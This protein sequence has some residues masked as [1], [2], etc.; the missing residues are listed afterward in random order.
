[1]RDA[2][3]Q[4]LVDLSRYLGDPDRGYAILGEGN[5]SARIDEDTF[6]V[7]ASGSVL[8]N[9]DGG[10]FVAVS[11]AKVLA[12]LDDPGADDAAVSRVLTEAR[13]D[14]GETRRPSVETLFHALLL[15]YPE[16][17]FVGHT[18]PIHT[19]ML[20]CSKKAEEAST[21]RICPDHVVVMAA[22]SV[23]VPYVDP[24]LVLARE[25]RARV[26]AFIETEGTLP[27]AIMMQGHGFIAVGDS[28]R[29]VMNITDMAEKA[30][31][32]IVGTYSLGG[33]VFMS[34]KDIA[35]IYTRPDEKYREKRLASEG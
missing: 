3:L 13:V 4:Q 2:I 26:E 23:F 19:N 21:G 10:G 9:I 25:I 28:P 30:A 14:P 11:R 17:K 20:L 33:P 24:G 1:M 29:T 16:I 31:R 6:Y 8:G 12:L 22:K 34:E 35:R 27:R 32:I 15:R 5:T 18:H 7:K